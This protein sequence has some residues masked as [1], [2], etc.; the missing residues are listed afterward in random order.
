MRKRAFHAFALQSLQILSTFSPRATAIGVNRC[1]LFRRLVGP[2]P[3]WCQNQNPLYLP[4]YF[5]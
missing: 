1:T 4:L 3:A 2:Y 5:R